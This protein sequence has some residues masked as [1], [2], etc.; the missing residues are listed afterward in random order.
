VIAMPLRPDAQS[1]DC[2]N[3]AIIIG[4]AAD[5]RG[6]KLV[7]TKDAIVQGGGYAIRL[8]PAISATSVNA[9]RGMRPWVQINSGE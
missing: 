9:W 2:T 3:A 8:K 6:P 5:C 7:L 4:A 1:E